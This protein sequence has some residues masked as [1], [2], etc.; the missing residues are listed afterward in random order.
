[1]IMTLKM[2]ILALTFVL[3][4]VLSIF[5]TPVKAATG[6][7]DYSS[8][9]GF[10][11]TIPA[12]WAG[13]YRTSDFSLAVEFINIGNEAAGYGGFLFSIV[14]QDNLE[15]LDWNGMKLLGQSGGLYYFGGVPSDVQFDYTNK[16]LM[17]EYQSMEKD[18]DAIFKSFR[19]GAASPA[20]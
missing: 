3:F 5:F 6:D 13:K 4:T 1:M 19:I 16:S 14:I 2:K 9:K 10:S 20:D 7:I 11:L 15:P 17:D 18:I 12:S 8:G